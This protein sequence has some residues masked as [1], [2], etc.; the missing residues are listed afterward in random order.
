MLPIQPS[1]VRASSSDPPLSVLIQGRGGPPPPPSAVHA[2]A[3]L[4]SAFLPHQV[5][6]PLQ[7]SAVNP[8]PL[9]QILAFTLQ[10]DMPHL[11]PLYTYD[12]PPLLSI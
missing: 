4:L 8:P 2:H 1:D 3:P 9:P 12:P 6:P 7:P 11:Q 5:E 10:Q